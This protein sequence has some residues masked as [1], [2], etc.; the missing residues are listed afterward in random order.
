MYDDDQYRKQQ[1]NLTNPKN[2]FLGL[3][4]HAKEVDNTW[5]CGWS[6]GTG[7][8]IFS[9]IMVIV[10][11]YDII[12]IASKKIFQ[13]PDISF[14]FKFFIVIKILS[15]IIAFVGIGISIYAVNRQNRLYSIV[16]YWVIVLVFLLNT[17]FVIYAIVAIFY[18]WDYIKYLIFLWFIMEFILLL[19]CWILFANQVYLGRVQ[20]AQAKQP[21]YL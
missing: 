14:T 21:G 7:V 16:A 13:S 8:I 10:V 17:I 1:E 4:C 11:I 3:F 6:F 9:V 20:N 19:Y 12:Y 15:D 18:Y 2:R 5:G